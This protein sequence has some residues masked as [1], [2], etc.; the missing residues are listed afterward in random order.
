MREYH[1]S[2]SLFDATSS[3]GVKHQINHEWLVSSFLFHL[4]Q[5]MSSLSFRRPRNRV[6]VI[7]IWSLISHM[8]CQLILQEKANKTSSGR[9]KGHGVQKW[10]WSHQK[11][12]FYILEKNSCFL[13]TTWTAS[14]KKKGL[15]LILFQLT[16]NKM[17]NMH[18]EQ[19]KKKK[20][21]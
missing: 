21:M 16:H 12:W 13:S 18:E 7:V 20:I 4:K 19:N 8:S 11:G 14:R 1:N 6:I 3:E 5:S 9:P 17:Q 15:S 10:S 2:Y